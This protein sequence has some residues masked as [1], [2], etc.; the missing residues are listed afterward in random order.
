[1]SAVQEAIG[2]RGKR[3]SHRITSPSCWPLLALPTS[4][5]VY[6]GLTLS[7]D[8][9]LTG[10]ELA[11][12]DKPQTGNVILFA[13]LLAAAVIC[14]EAMRRL[15]Q[16]TWRFPRPAVR[17][18]AAHRAVAAAA[19]RSAGA[20]APRR[21]ALPASAAD[22]RPPPRVQLSRARASGRSGISHVSSQFPQ[23]RRGGHAGRFERLADPPAGG[24][25]R[26]RVRCPVRR[27]ER[28]CRRGRRA[29]G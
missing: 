9:A 18:V 29:P 24:A 4:L 5:I 17:M 20:V 1:M 27:G 22:T 28:R 25:D 2:Q 6:I 10:W 19:V 15:G 8:L 26:D 23:S 3:L 14:I 21:G 12:I 7:A 13:V 11:G 16:P